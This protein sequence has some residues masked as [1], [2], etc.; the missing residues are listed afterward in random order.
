MHE[1]KRAGEQDD[2]RPAEFGSSN[3]QGIEDAEQSDRNLKGASLLHDPCEDATVKSAVLSTRMA[4][5]LLQMS[6]LMA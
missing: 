5:L 6:T 4:G 2:D 1:R 3:G